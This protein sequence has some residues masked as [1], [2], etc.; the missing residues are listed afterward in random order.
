MFLAEDDRSALK[1][2]IIP[3]LEKIS[4]AD[5][6]ILADY[7]IALIGV[8][9]TEEAV[10]ENCLTS[11][12]DF[13]HEETAPFIDVVLSAVKTRS[14]V[15]STPPA[16]GT[17]HTA[18]L[19][20]NTGIEAVPNNSVSTL[21]AA[22]PAFKPPTGPAALLGEHRPPAGAPTS[23]SNSRNSAPKRKYNERESSQPFDS[24]DP[25]HKRVRGRGSNSR[26]GH[27]NHN[28]T[29]G[30]AM[31]GPPHTS[32]SFGVPAGMMAGYPPPPAMPA[33]FPVGLIPDPMAFLAMMGMPMQALPVS[34]PNFYPNANS[35]R[36]G[37]SRGHKGRCRDYDTKGYCAAGSACP[38]EHGGAFMMQPP[39]EEYDPNQALLDPNGSRSARGSDGGPPNRNRTTNNK[40]RSRASFSQVG[41]NHDRSNSTIVVEQIPEEYFTADAVRAFFSQFGEIVNIEMHPSKRLAIVKFGDYNAARRAY[42]SPKVIFDNRF[43]KV[44]WYKNQPRLSQSDAAQGDVN[45]EGYQPQKQDEEMVDMEE[46][47]KRQAEAQ[48]AFEERQKLAQ[49]AEARQAELERRLQEIEDEKR[50]LQEALRKKATNGTANVGDDSLA[51]Q[52]SLL[53]AEAQ[54][55]S[56]EQSTYPFRGRGR[57]GYRGGYRGRV[58]F[59][60]RGRGYAPFG[61]GYRGRGGGYAPF[62]G[63]RS[64]VKRLDNRPKRVAVSNVAVGSKT[65]E[66]LREHL[67]KNY[68]YES[69]EPHPSQPDTQIVAFKERYM[70]ETFTDLV[71]HA[72]ELSHVELAWVPNTATMSKTEPSGRDQISSDADAKM[73]EGGAEEAEQSSEQANAEDTNGNANGGDADYDVADDE[74]RW[75]AT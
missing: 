54:G 47:E 69:V 73:D 22:A 25:A 23:P 20:S 30:G 50:Q 4:E 11:L 13:L 32:G 34:P 35:G 26:N 64:G 31:T 38:Y 5:A 55:L 65:E 14:F 18:T 7:V 41:A 3:K 74:D 56:A 17:V 44:Y 72:P 10:K 12:S 29:A 57:G 61:G 67:V 52:L 58:T 48:K 62:A 15:P 39:V 37:R 24:Y 33:G 27:V 8:D 36:A 28:G 70:A 49:E 40:S 66:A 1:D 68:D 21:S 42:E 45:E 6:S 2:W 51:D 16:P 59:V 75:L 60:P 9:D 19:A 43:V 63:G 71:R 53:Q 46:F